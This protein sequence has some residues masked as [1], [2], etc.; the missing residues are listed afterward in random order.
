MKVAVIGAAGWVG[1]AVL[2]GFAGRH[3]VRAFDFSPES[4]EQY[5][6]YDGEWEEGVRWERGSHRRSTIFRTARFSAASIRRR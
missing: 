2:E 1:R 6:Q 5:A 3:E 4:W